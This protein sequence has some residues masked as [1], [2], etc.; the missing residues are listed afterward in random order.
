MESI[1]D[2]GKVKYEEL[3]QVDN[4]NSMYFDR[5]II[6]VVKE[7]EEYRSKFRRILVACLNTNQEYVY[8]PALSFILKAV[9]ESVACEQEAFEKFF[10]LFRIWQEEYR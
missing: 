5:D 3:D 6:R 2:N 10:E 4:W 8:Y 9:M 7:D 1:Q